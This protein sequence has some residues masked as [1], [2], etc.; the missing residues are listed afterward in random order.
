M[1][2]KKITTGK[3]LGI[4]I[5]SSS[6]K[7]AEITCDSDGMVVTALGEAPMPEDL[8][9]N[10]EIQNVRQLASIIKK[11][12]KD[13]G[14]SCKKSVF[15]I[16]APSNNLVR[17]LEVP[18]SDN[19][20]Q[21]RMSVKYEVERLFP[22]SSYDTEFDY[23]ELPGGTDTA[24]NVF[25][26]ASYSKLVEDLLNVANMAGLQLDAIEVG[27]LAMGRSLIEQLQVEDPI[28]GIVDLGASKSTICVFDGTTVK[29]PGMAI[30]VSGNTFTN[31]ISESMGTSFIEA[32]EFKKDYAM[33][34]MD[35]IR[36]YYDKKYSND[37]E[38]DSSSFDTAFDDPN[39]NPA[40]ASQ[41]EGNEQEFSADEDVFNFNNDDS[42]MTD[43]P[44]E[45]EEEKSETKTPEKEEKFD[46]KKENEELAEEIAAKGG[47]RFNLDDMEEETDATG[48]QDQKFVEKDPEKS[49]D[50]CRIILEELENL[51]NEIRSQ[52]DEYYNTTGVN[53]Q[54]I[55]LT[56]GT[57]KLPGL[58]EFLEEYLGIEVVKGNP[59]DI[60]R[61][62]MAQTNME[63]LE[64]LNSVYPVAIGL[65]M[66]DFI[67]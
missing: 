49:D 30:S 66:R 50:I 58:D 6:V 48:K 29:N 19:P 47:V 54:K 40:Y 59:R 51:Q 37:F 22:H 9:V 63:I 44:F 67:E 4:D 1:A 28:C 62:R 12:C 41:Q 14:S 55:M 8:F 46:I 45:A 7:V 2:D 18:R 11:I 32:E 13:C 38:F 15:A 53:V 21:T 25:V 57:S 10:E 39:Y 24:S 36:E 65:A 20:K 33:L 43:N 34:N 17:A 64:D 26:A 35:I 42:S 23:V 16:S 52:L 60:V 27:E 5:G 61:F 31:A 3:L 56:G